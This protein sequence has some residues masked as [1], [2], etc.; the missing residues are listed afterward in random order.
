[1]YNGIIDKKN[2]HFSFYEIQSSNL[3]LNYP[4][5]LTN[6][7]DFCFPQLHSCPSI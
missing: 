2:P 1:M 4:N 5:I 3:N 7:I 6:Q